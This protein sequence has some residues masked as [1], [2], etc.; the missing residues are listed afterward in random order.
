MPSG[1]G[2]EQV[3]SYRGLRIAFRLATMDERRSPGGDR[4]IAWVRE[5]PNLECFAATREDVLDRIKIVIDN[6]T[7]GE[8]HSG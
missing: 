3:V 2:G 6:P 1:Q 4:W 5:N 7:T 8:A